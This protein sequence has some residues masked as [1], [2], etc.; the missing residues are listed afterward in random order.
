MVIGGLIQT[1]LFAYFLRRKFAFKLYIAYISKFALRACAQLLVIGS[2]FYVVYRLCLLAFHYCSGSYAHF[3]IDSFG[4]L[5]W[6]ALLSVAMCGVLFMTRKAFD[7][8]D[9][10]FR[11]IQKYTQALMGTDV[12]KLAMLK[13]I[14]KQN[15]ILVGL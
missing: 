15:V 1:M 7:I 11:L 8:K 6:I 5:L 13:L 12:N 14:E 4:F 9:L 3:F 10:F 2:I